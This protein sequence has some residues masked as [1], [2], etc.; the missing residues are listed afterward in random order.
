MPRVMLVAAK[1]LM[2]VTEKGVVMAIVIYLIYT[3]KRRSVF[4]VVFTHTHTQPQ[5]VGQSESQQNTSKGCVPTVMMRETTTSLAW[6][7]TE[8]HSVPHPAVFS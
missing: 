2:E 4:A 3:R 8:H 6:P 7:I 1:D 5:R